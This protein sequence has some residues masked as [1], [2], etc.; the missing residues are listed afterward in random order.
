MSNL[1]N[2]PSISD[3]M[4][5][6]ITLI[7]F[8]IQVFTPNCLDYFPPQKSCKRGRKRPPKVKDDIYHSKTNLRERERERGRESMREREDLCL[9]A[10][11]ARARQTYFSTSRMLNFPHFFSF[12]GEKSMGDIFAQTCLHTREKICKYILALSLFRK[13]REG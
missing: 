6:L 12:C 2:V 7:F 5:S 8:L 4:H 3:T 1:Q 9:C 10:L 13:E 11:L